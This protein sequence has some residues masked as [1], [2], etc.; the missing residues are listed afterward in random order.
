MSASKPKTQLDIIKSFLS[1][2]KEGRSSAGGNLYIKG[3]RLIHYQTTIAERYGEKI[4][5][6]YTRYSL[7]TGKIQKAIKEMVPEEKLISIGR[8][9]INYD[10]SLVDKV[11]ESGVETQ[12]LTSSLKRTIKSFFWNDSLRITVISFAR[13]PIL[14][15]VLPLTGKCYSSF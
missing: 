10:K 13:P 2:E 3:D 6:N 9:T 4:I 12:R 11:K 7:V 15:A 1:G 14:I 5:L 8:I